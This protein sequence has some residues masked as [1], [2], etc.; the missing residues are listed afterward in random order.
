MRLEE[1]RPSGLSLAVRNW[2]Q[3]VLLHERAADEQVEDLIVAAKLD[4][5]LEG[6][7]IVCLNERIEEL[8]Q[9]DRLM[10]LI[11]RAEIVALHHPSQGV[12]SG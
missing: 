2:L 7:R 8:V 9:S 5:G 1:S 3:P 6:D 4:V 11:A 12:L 10:G